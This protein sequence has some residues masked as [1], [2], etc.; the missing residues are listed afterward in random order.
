LF[1]DYPKHIETPM[2]RYSEH[3][4]ESFV[5]FTSILLTK[6]TAKTDQ[7]KNEKYYFSK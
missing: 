4:N 5:A 6:Y 3:S 1:S 7:L 2:N